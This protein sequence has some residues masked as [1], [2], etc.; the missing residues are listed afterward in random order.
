MNGEKTPS[1]P[2]TESPILFYQSDY[3]T[4]RNEVRLARRG[5]RE[6]IRENKKD[7]EIVSIARFPRRTNKLDIPRVQKA[8]IASSLFYTL[9]SAMLLLVSKVI[10]TY[11]AGN[12]FCHINYRCCIIC[13]LFHAGEAWVNSHNQECHQ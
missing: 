9:I 2:V 5:N 1:V 3:R 7:S 12:Y 10:G 4:C 13:R 8:T 11:A 6:S